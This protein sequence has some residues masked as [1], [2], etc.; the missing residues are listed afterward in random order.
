MSIR[1]KSLSEQRNLDA[2]GSLAFLTAL[3]ILLLNDFVLKP[4]LH[5]GATEQFEDSVIRRLRSMR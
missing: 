3:G 4:A 1:A 5:N 2:L